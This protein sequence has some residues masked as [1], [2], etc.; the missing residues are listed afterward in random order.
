MVIV[1]A[2]TAAARAALAAALEDAAITRGLRLLIA[3]DPG[4]A[5][6]AQGLHLPEKRL[7]EAAHWRARYPHWIIT[8][9]VHSLKALVR[10]Q[11]LDIDALLLSPVF[12]TTS[13]AGAEPLT[14]VRAASIAAASRLPV[15]ALGGVTG[16]NATRLAPA[17]DGIA[18][19]GALLA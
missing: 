7:G 12:A 11:T 15:Y 1:R 19:I 8:A 14:P 6:Q 18:A 9:A 17:F 4:L 2:R 13:H 16:A 3:D 10:A 5:A